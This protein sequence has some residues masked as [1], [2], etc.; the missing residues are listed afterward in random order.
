MLGWIFRNKD[1]APGPAPAVAAARPQAVA[2]PAAPAVDWSARLDQ[3]RGDD[4]ALLALLRAAGVP[5]QTRLAAVEALDGEAALKQAELESRSHDRR[6][7]QLAKRRL[8]A[9]VAGRQTREQAARLIASA[10]ELAAEADVAVNRGVEL[11]RAW[12]ALD[13]AA[14]EPA[15]R[16]EF[17]ALSAQLA[18][19]ARR[20]ADIELQ[21]KRWQAECAQALRGLQAACTGAAAGTQDRVALAAAVGAARD[22][23]AALPQGDAAT[24]ATA[25]ALAPLQ[26]ALQVAEVL[27]GH[28]AVL[29][30]LFAAPGVADDGVPETGADT[31]PA[32]AWQA[33]PPLPDAPLAAL[34]QARHAQWQQGLD[35]AQRQAQS[36]RREQARAQQRARKGEQGV[37]LADHVAQAEAALD[38]GQLADAHAHLTEIDAALHGSEAPETLHVRLAAAQARLAQLRGWQHWAG[39]RARDELVLQAEALAAATVAARADPAED[40]PVS[41]AD[42]EVARLSIRQR[43]DVIATLRE[44]W[45]EVDRLGGAGSR[46][47]WQRFDAALKAAHAPVAAHVA[48]QRAQR[49]ANLAAR[50]ALLQ[51]LEAAGAA[52][53]AAPLAGA[54]DAAPPPADDAVPADARTLAA[55]LDRFQIEWRK[56]GPPEHT[57]PREARAALAQRA[58]A[59][60]RRVEAP[61]QAARG[62]ARAEREALVARARA[63]VVQA[64]DRGRELGPEVR[65]L[66]AEWQQHARALPLAR[67]DEQALWNDF[68]AAIDGAFA[69]R[70]AEFNAREAEFEAHAAERAALIERLRVRAEDSPVAQRR[71]L[72]EVDAAWQRCGPAPRARAA[73]L[74]GE[75]R[76][77]REA[78]RQWLDEAAQRSWQAGCDALDA[79]LAL[80]LEREQ[81]AG[82]EGEALAAAWQALA[83]LPAPLEDAL[84]RRAGLTP[85]DGSAPTPAVDELLLQIEAAWDLPT[86][87]AF[88]AARRERKLLALKASLEGRRA[89]AAEALPPDAALAR[90]LGRGPLDA[91]QRDRLDAVLAARRRRG[92]Q[93]AA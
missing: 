17:A 63:L 34:L 28:L 25:A 8:Q 55:A 4:D 2:A 76:A 35:Q 54:D 3:A 82:V 26:H 21:R 91:G 56:L 31:D 10:R 62:Q 32:K 38:A 39:G 59:A 16:D 52:G 58:E 75:F 86:P 72:A 7:H 90:L 61:L 46:A 18:G 33:L 85:H 84:R 66:Q 43:A 83:A 24:P 44:R 22:V 47:L 29:D 23:A 30:R 14:I 89:P 87:P 45:K 50:L 6:V 53:D 74:E 40:G 69:A 5:W 15:Q 42:A 41:E 71:L 80:C 36:Q 49:E 73:A 11:D 57:V 92:P 9:R 13:A 78:L 67:A 48:A 60:L 12:Q 20:R 27:D 65:A 88:E 51:A 1:K 68:R 64:S 81:G 79:K 77:A 70:D 37:A 93:R 19:Q